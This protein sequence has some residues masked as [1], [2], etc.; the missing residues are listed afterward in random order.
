MT[1]IIELLKTLFWVIISWS[2]FWIAVD[3]LIKR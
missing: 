1:V 3:F 2:L